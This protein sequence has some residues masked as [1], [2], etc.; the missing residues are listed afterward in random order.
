MLAVAIGSDELSF[1]AFAYQL[2]E[3]PLR[4][5]LQVGFGLLGGESRN[6]CRDAAAEVANG[7][8]AR[9]CAVAKLRRRR[10]FSRGGET[11]GCAKPFS[12]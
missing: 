12:R 11:R 7:G 6:R 3:E 5:K 10:E 8:V 2:S 4:L 9:E 1:S